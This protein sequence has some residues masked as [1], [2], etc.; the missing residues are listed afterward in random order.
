M[1][2]HVKIHQPISVLVYQSLRL[3]GHSFLRVLPLSL[4]IG[5]L[6]AFPIVAT[7]K[8]TWGLSPELLS[9]LSILFVLISCLLTG[10]MYQCF[11]MMADEQPVSYGKA[12]GTVL[13]RA[14][15]ILLVFIIVSVL[16]WVGMLF[17]FLPGIMISLYSA[18]AV[19]IVVLSGI[20]AING[21]VK[22]CK[23]VYGQWWQSLAVLIIPMVAISLTSAL[24]QKQLD[25][26]Y[27][28]MF[29]LFVVV[30]P[31]MNAAIFCQ[32][33]NL[34]HVPNES[35]M[36]AKVVELLP[37]R[38][39]GLKVACWLFFIYLLVSFAMFLFPKLDSIIN[40]NTT[41]FG[42]LHLI[43]GALLVVGCLLCLP[44]IFAFY[45]YFASVISRTIW[46]WLSLLSIIFYAAMLIRGHLT[47]KA[48]LTA[49]HT[50][51]IIFAVI[52]V[53]LNLGVIISLMG[54][55]VRAW[56]KQ[57]NEIKNEKRGQSLK[58]L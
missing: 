11:Q 37:S 31:W 56:F 27:W 6:M 9:G 43:Q 46:I 19:P 25:W 54:K 23:L 38:P 10:V 18:F 48:G 58:D 53:A 8:S 49:N 36:P 40:A 47:I 26:A 1:Y 42:Y 57:I 44:L 15:S 55:G 3:W 2:K 52:A 51:V 24:A 14:G 21:F 13:K 22:S 20:S 32:Y 35:R 16:N 12:I 45:S 30:I 34:Q 50:D 39:S 33:H 41:F 29:I 7:H 5:I 28:L 4:I 17:A